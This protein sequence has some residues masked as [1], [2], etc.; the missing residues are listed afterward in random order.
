M[1]KR[2]FQRIPAYLESHCFNIDYF[3]TVTN[4][5]ED[6]MF[7]RSQKIIF[8]LELQFEISIPL[9]GEILNVP[10]KVERITKSNKYY[11]GIGVRLLKQPKNYLK[12]IERLRFAL[13]ING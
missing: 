1:E 10:V 7:I 13:K 5:S 6:G 3:G 4:L 8:P 12:F 2:A 9:K 11:D